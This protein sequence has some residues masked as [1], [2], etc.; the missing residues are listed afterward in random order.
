[1]AGEITAG[2]IEGGGETRYL[3]LEGRVLFILE[4]EGFLHT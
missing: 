1:M 2:A 3:V 4:F